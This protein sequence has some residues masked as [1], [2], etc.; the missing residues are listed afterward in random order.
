MQGITP[1]IWF[2]GTA[3]EAMNFYVSTFKNSKIVDI[4][5][6]AGDQ[7]IPGEQELK[8]KVLN[9]TFE[10]NGQRFMCLDGGPQFP[11]SGAISFMVE[12][13]NQEELDTVWAAMLDGGKTQQCGWI[14]DK[15]GVTW[16]IV[17]ASLGK[18][19]GDPAATPEQKKAVM[20]AMMPM[21]KLDGPA[22]EKAF[23]GAK[24]A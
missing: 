2:E 3:E 1:F 17:P 9:G 19:L 24:K 21:V 5:R 6:Y 11:M 14:T 23:E 10:L 8:G 22:L 13:D 18:M 15:F 4:E 12:F 7:G 16:Q 20:Q